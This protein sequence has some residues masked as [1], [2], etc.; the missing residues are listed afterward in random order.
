MIEKERFRKLPKVII[1]LGLILFVSVQ[2]F[3]IEKAGVELKTFKEKSNTIDLNDF[4][5]AFYAK[6]STK[7]S[8]N[9][10]KISLYGNARITTKQVT[11]LADVITYNATTQI[12]TARNI[13]SFKFDGNDHT[14]K[15][16]R[17]LTSLK[18]TEHSYEIID[19]KEL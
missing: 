2:T 6:D 9:K 7:F 11:L 4:K 3:S 13:Q 18:L 19:N 14:L 17:A 12:M 8:K 10:E 5:L 1:L 15:I 16:N